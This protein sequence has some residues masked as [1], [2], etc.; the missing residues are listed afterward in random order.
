MTHYFVH[1]LFQDVCSWH[2]DPTSGIVM[3]GGI[4][5][6]THSSLVFVERALKS[7]MYIQKII[8][9]ILMAFL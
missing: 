1:K 7:A 5:Y 3:Q 8:Q 6:N 2:N 9:P 4:S